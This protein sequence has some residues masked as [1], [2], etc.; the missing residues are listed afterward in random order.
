MTDDPWEADRAEIDERHAEASIEDAEDGG[1]R[2]DSEI[3]PQREL[4][5]ARDRGAFDGGDHGLSE[6]KTRRAHRTELAVRG[7]RSRLAVGNRL[8]IGPGAEASARAGQHRHVGGRV[9]VEALEGVKQGARGRKVDGV[10][11]LRT[12]D[13]HHRDAPVDAG[14]NGASC[15]D[16]LSHGPL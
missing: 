10:A 5:T 13:R 1:A 14:R 15:L 3:A 7:D 8:E 16:R 9:G 11:P 6:R 12:F 4:Q 2:G